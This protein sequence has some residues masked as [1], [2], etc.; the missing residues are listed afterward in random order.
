MAIGAAE[1]LY[2]VIYRLPFWGVIG[3]GCNGGIKWH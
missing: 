2:M 1:L 3:E